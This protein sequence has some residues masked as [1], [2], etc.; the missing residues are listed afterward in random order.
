LK[1]TVPEKQAYFSGATVN[2]ARVAPSPTR[3]GVRHGKLETGNRDVLFPQEHNFAKFHENLSSRKLD[4][5]FR[6]SA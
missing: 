3:S 6:S 2:G 5:F 1:K 4:H